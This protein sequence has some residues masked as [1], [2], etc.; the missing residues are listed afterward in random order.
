MRVQANASKAGRAKG[1]RGFANSWWKRPHAAAHT[2]NTYL[3]AQYHR[4]AARQGAKTAMIAVGHT[5]LTVIYHMLCEH[6]PYTDL[7]GNYFD[8]QDR[9]VTQKRLVRRLEKLGYQV[10]VSAA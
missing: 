3:S 6:Q 5:L 2:K 9:Q 4:I 8:E 1:V 7:G 10:S